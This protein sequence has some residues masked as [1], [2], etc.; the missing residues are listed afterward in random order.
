VDAVLCRGVL[1]DLIDEDSRRPVFVSFAGAMRQEAALILDVRE[2]RSTAAQKTHRPV[3][4]KTVETERGRLT[5]RS[6]TKLQPERRCLLVSETH[7]LEAPGGRQVAFC[8]FATRCWTQD[9]L[10]RNLARAGFEPVEC[11]GDYDAAKPVGATDRLVA[12]ATLRHEKQ[13]SGARR[14]RQ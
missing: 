2:W 1:N 11:F 6:V 7:V 12:A 13:A 14:S 3:F 10:A 4:E 5:F 9:E 8:D